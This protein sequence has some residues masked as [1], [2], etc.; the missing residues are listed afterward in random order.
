MWIN[1]RSLP[2][3]EAREDLAVADLPVF[4]AAVISRGGQLT[5]DPVRDP[6]ADRDGRF[7]WDLPMGDGRVVRP[8]LPGA[9]LMRVRDDLTRRPPAFARCCRKAA[10]HPRRSG[11]RW[12]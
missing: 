6:A 9:G 10:G 1:P 7:S 4:L 5:A 11:T 8:L 2:V 12:C 3:D